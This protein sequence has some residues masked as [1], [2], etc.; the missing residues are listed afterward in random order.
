MK[1]I[2]IIVSSF[3]FI[4]SISGKAQSALSDS[5]EKTALEYLEKKKTTVKKTPSDT[6]LNINSTV[7]ETY[8]I[9]IKT[10]S[11]PNNKYIIC[12]YG[13]NV[14]LCKE[15][16]STIYKIVTDKHTNLYFKNDFISPIT[17][18]KDNNHFFL[19]DEECETDRESIIHEP[20]ITM[21]LLDSK[22]SI[23]KEFQSMSIQDLTEDILCQTAP[24]SISRAKVRKKYGHL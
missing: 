19:S 3:L 14:K 6:I 1:K 12:L 20:I 11:I 21:L 15:E 2:L 13:I 4:F 22:F 5:L 16:A 18:N 8:S 17:L 23:V 7:P 24:G 10:Y 9:V